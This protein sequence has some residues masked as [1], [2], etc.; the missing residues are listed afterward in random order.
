[1]GYLN[2][3]S[4]LEL[5]ARTDPEELARRR[6]EWDEWLGRMVEAEQP[7]CCGNCCFFV[8]DYVGS[9]GVCVRRSPI[10]SYEFPTM[11]RELWCGDWEKA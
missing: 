5:I 4:D 2:Y 11:R 7:Q 9:Y 8:T 1:M 10:A 3:R 6:Q